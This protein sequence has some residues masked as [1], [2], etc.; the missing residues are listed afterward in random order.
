[1]L[2]RTADQFAFAV[3]TGSLTV[4]DCVEWA[5]KNI[6]GL[7]DLIF[8]DSGGSSQLLVGYDVPVYTGRKIPNVL[9]FYAYKT[10]AQ[11]IIPDVPEDPGEDPEPD[12][13]PEPDP[14]EDP[15]DQQIQ[16]L[17]EEV[18]RLR[19]KLEQIKAIAAE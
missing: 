3:V 13:Q 11:P 2:I 10:E 1:M 14:G 19:A 7:M 16:Q 9:A 4:A 18:E 12:P 15:R 8:M 5:E 17:Q 6:S